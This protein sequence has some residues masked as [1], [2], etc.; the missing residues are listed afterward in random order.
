MPVAAVKVAAER[1]TRSNVVKDADLAVTAAYV[2]GR[3]TPEGGFSYYRAWGVEEPGAADT[4]HAVAA[5][6]TLGSV[7]DRSEDCVQWLRDR[8]SEDGGY[9]GI[10]TAWHVVEALACLSAAPR[11]NPAQWLAPYSERLFDG[12]D[13]E[14]SGGEV[15]LSL[16]RHV[17]LRERLSLAL[18]PR[19]RNAIS[20][21]LTRIRDANG[22]FPR[23]GANLVD[24][25]VALR[26]LRSAGLLP[27]RRLLEF[28]LACENPASGFC[29]VAEGQST[30]LGALAAGVAIMHYFDAAP[31]Y[32]R[33]LLDLT[34]ACRHPTGGYGRHIGAV[35]TLHDTHLA[36]YLINSVRS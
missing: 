21:N 1:E 9:A 7:P 10:A 16:T 15:L 3:Q 23:G 4:W 18:E 5:L 12:M 19:H 32:P 28:A 25:A 30:H 33:S 29:A 11:H 13:A 8:Q 20:A 35:A 17:E 26:L 14:V 24:S 27:D 2:R 34:M 36:V 6:A 22:G 31:A